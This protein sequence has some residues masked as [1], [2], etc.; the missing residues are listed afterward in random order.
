MKPFSLLTRE[1]IEQFEIDCANYF[2]GGLIDHSRA[3]S[4]VNDLLDEENTFELKVESF[5]YLAHMS[6]SSG[7]IGSTSPKWIDTLNK[8]QKGKAIR[9]P[10]YEEGADLEGWDQDIFL[11]VRTYF[12]V[13]L[14]INVKSSQQ[15]PPA[16]ITSKK[17]LEFLRNEILITANAYRII[18]FI[19]QKPLED[20]PQLF[21]EF[22][23]TITDFL[24]QM[25][26]L[27]QFCFPAGIKGHAIY[28]FFIRYEN[29]LVV[30]I[31]NFQKDAKKHSY[32]KRIE[33]RKEVQYSKPFC[34]AQIP[35]MQSRL[36]ED[37]SY[38]VKLISYLETISTAKLDANLDSIK[39][40][41]DSHGLLEV[42][43]NENDFG[44][45]RTQTV[46]NCVYINFN[47]STQL[48][49]LAFLNWHAPVYFYDREAEF[50]GRYIDVN[51]QNG[52]WQEYR[53]LISKI[54]AVEEGALRDFGPFQISM[55]TPTQRSSK[56]KLLKPF[57]GTSSFAEIRHQNFIYIDKSL[58]IKDII[59]TDSREA[60]VKVKVFTRPTRFGKSLNMSMIGYYLDYRKR[61]RSTHDN[62]FN[63][64]NNLNIQTVLG[65]SECHQN[66]YMVISLDF[67]QIASTTLDEF[68]IKLKRYFADLYDAYS[69]V[70]ESLIDGSRA[71]N[72]FYNIQ[73]YGEP[74][75]PDISDENLES[76]LKNL[77]A[78]CTIY[79]SLNNGKNHLREIKPIV[80]I[81][82]YDSPL[83]SARIHGFWEKAVDLLRTILLF[84]FK[85]NDEN[86]SKAVITGVTRLAGEKLFSPLGNNA[87]I[88]SLT[89]ER[90]SDCFGLTEEEL[91]VILVNSQY[92]D[93]ID[94]IMPQLERY[95]GHYYFGKRRLFN[96][97]SVFQALFKNKHTIGYHRY[98][99]PNEQ[100]KY[101]LCKH[102]LITMTDEIK[103]IIKEELLQLVNNQ[104]IPLPI[105]EAVSMHSDATLAPREW[106]YSLLYLCG[107]ITRIPVEDMLPNVHDYEMMVPNYECQQYFIDDILPALGVHL[108]NEKSLQF[109]KDRAL[110]IKDHGD[111]LIHRDFYLKNFGEL[112]KHY[113]VSLSIC[114]LLEWEDIPIHL[115]SDIVKACQATMPTAVEEPQQFMPTLRDKYWV[116]LDVDT[117]RFSFNS[118]SAHETLVH[119]VEE[120]NAALFNVPF[121][122]T[123]YK[124][125]TQQFT[126]ALFEADTYKPSKA[127][128]NHVFTMTCYLETHQQWPEGIVD[129]WIR[130]MHYYLYHGFNLDKA[131][132][133]YKLYD[134]WFQQT[135]NSL[136]SLDS[137][138]QRAIMYS[139]YGKLSCRLN[140]LDPNHTLQWFANADRLF[141]ES[142]QHPATAQEQWLNRVR[143]AKYYRQTF[144]YGDCYHCYERALSHCQSGTAEY[145]YTQIEMTFIHSL[146]MNEDNI[147]PLSLE[148]AHN[149]CEHWLGLL[150]KT[151]D[152]TAL[153]MKSYIRVAIVKS[154]L[155]NSDSQ[156]KNYFQK[157]L[158]MVNE[159]GGKE[160]LEYNKVLCSSYIVL[161]DDMLT[162]ESFSQTMVHIKTA[163]DSFYGAQDTHIV[164][165]RL[166][167]AQAIYYSQ[168]TI[169]LTKAKIFYDKAKE[170]LARIKATI[171]VQTSQKKPTQYVDRLILGF[172]INIG[173]IDRDMGNMQAAEKQTKTCLDNVCPTGP[174]VVVL[175]NN[176][177]ELA[178]SR[179]DFH[180]A[181]TRFDT[182]YQEMLK[183]YGREHV[184]TLMV[185]MNQLICRCYQGDIVGSDSSIQE[186]VTILRDAYSAGHSHQEL[187]NIA[188]QLSEAC[189]FIGNVYYARELIECA[190]EFY[191]NKKVQKVIVLSP[192][193]GLYQAIQ[194]FCMAIAGDKSAAMAKF[195]TIYQLFMMHQWQTYPSYYAILYYVCHARYAQLDMDGDSIQRNPFYA[196]SLSTLL[197]ELKA[198]LNH[199]R[200][201]FHTR[202]SQVCMLETKLHY[203]IGDFGT[204]HNSLREAEV[205]YQ[206]ISET[207]FKLMDVYYLETKM[208]SKC[209]LLA[210]RSV[211]ESRARYKK[212]QDFSYGERL[213][214]WAKRLK[215]GLLCRPMNIGEFKK[216]LIDISQGNN[217]EFHFVNDDVEKK[218][219]AL[220]I[221]KNLERGHVF[222]NVNGLGIAGVLDKITQ[223]IAL[224]L[225]R[226]DIEEVLAWV[227]EYQQQLEEYKA[228]TGD[229]FQIDTDKTVCLNLIYSVAF[230]PTHNGRFADLMIPIINEIPDE[231]RILGQLKAQHLHNLACW[232]NVQ[233]EEDT[234]KGNPEAAAWF[235]KAEAI[236]E[237]LKDKR[238]KS[239]VEY[240]HIL[241][242]KRNKQHY[243]RIIALLFH[244]GNFHPTL[245]TQGPTEYLNYNE[246]E[247]LLL[248]LSLRYVFEFHTKLRINIRLL[249][250]FLGCMTLCDIDE[251]N[252]PMPLESAIGDFKTIVDNTQAEQPRLFQY[253]G[254]YLLGCLYLR[255]GKQNEAKICFETS[256]KLYQQENPTASDT[257]L[258]NL[259]PCI[260]LDSL[261]RGLTLL[262]EIKQRKEKSSFLVS[263]DSPRRAAVN[264][265]TTNHSV[266]MAP[267]VFDW[268]SF[269]DK[270]LSSITQ[271][272]LYSGIDNVQILSHLEFD[273]L[274][275][276]LRTP[277]STSF[278]RNL[279]NL[280]EFQQLIQQAFETLKQAVP[281]FELPLLIMQ[282]DRLLIQ[283]PGTNMLKVFD[284]F[285]KDYLPP[286]VQTQSPLF[287]VMDYEL[288]TQSWDNDWDNDHKLKVLQSWVGDGLVIPNDVLLNLTNLIGLSPLIIKALTKY[289]QANPQLSFENFR[290]EEHER[291][292][293]DFPFKERDDDT[294]VSLSDRFFIPLI[295]RLRNELGLAPLLLGGTADKALLSRLLPLAVVNGFIHETW[296]STNEGSLTVAI[297]SHTQASTTILKS[298]NELMTKLWRIG[299]LKWEAKKQCY[300]LSP[301]LQRLLLNAVLQRY[302]IDLKP[303][304]EQVIYEFNAQFTPLFFNQ[305]FDY[306]LLCPIRLMYALSYQV[307]QLAT[308]TQVKPETWNEPLREAYALLLLRAA[309]GLH[310]EGE[311]LQ[312]KRL[313]DEAIALREKDSPG[314]RALTN[315]YYYLMLG[316]YYLVSGTLAEALQAFEKVL[317]KGVQT[318]TEKLLSQQQAIEA[319][320]SSRI[321]YVKFKQESFEAFNHLM[322]AIDL[323]QYLQK[324]KPSAYFSVEHAITLFYYGDCYYE[325]GHTDR[326]KKIQR[327]LKTAA[328][329]DNPYAIAIECYQQARACLVDFY[330]Q[331]EGYYQTKPDQHLYVAEVNFRLGRCQRVQGRFLE[332]EASLKAAMATFL[333]FYEK[334]NHNKIVLC[335]LELAKLDIDKRAP[336]DALLGRMTDLKPSMNSKNQSV[337]TEFHFVLGKIHQI[338]GDHQ[339]AKTC[340]VDAMRSL[341]SHAQNY[342][343]DSIGYSANTQLVQAISLSDGQP[344]QRIRHSLA[345]RILHQLGANAYKM[346]LY[347]DAIVLLHEAL[348]INLSRLDENWVFDDTLD[349]SQPEQPVY[350]PAFIVLNRCKHPRMLLTLYE[351]GNC[352]F[353]LGNYSLA[354]WLLKTVLESQEDIYGV[355][356]QALPDI[357]ATSNSLARVYLELGQWSNA[358]NWVS[359]PAHGVAETFEE[360]GRHHLAGQLYLARGDVQRAA[361]ELVQGIHLAQRLRQH[362]SS[363]QPHLVETRLLVTAGR[364]LLS[365]G[366]PI[367]SKQL[368]ER[369]LTLY[370]LHYSAQSTELARLY[371]ELAQFYLIHYDPIQ[372]TNW[373]TTSNA[374]YQA[375]FHLSLDDFDTRIH[376]PDL[377][378]WH[379]SRTW[380]TYIEAQHLLLTDNLVFAITKFE[381]ALLYYQAIHIAEGKASGNVLFALAGVYL[382]LYQLTKQVQYKDGFVRCFDTLLQLLESILQKKNPDAIDSVSWWPMVLY[383]YTQLGFQHSDDEAIQQ[384]CRKWVGV[385]S[386]LLLLLETKARLSNAFVEAFFTDINTCHSLTAAIKQPPLVVDGYLQLARLANV[387]NDD[388]LTKH[389]LNF[390]NKLI[391]QQTGHPRQ[392]YWCFYSDV[393]ATKNQGVDSSN[394]VNSIQKLRERFETTVAQAREVTVSERDY[395]RSELQWMEQSPQ[396]SLLRG[397]MNYLLPKPSLHMSIPAVGSVFPNITR[398]NIEMVLTTLRNQHAYVILGA[399]G[400]GKTELVRDV[401]Q[402]MAPLEVISLS[403]ASTDLFCLSLQEL[404]SKLKLGKIYSGLEQQ[405]L[406]ATTV[407]LLEEASSVVFLLDGFETVQRM[408]SLVS[409]FLT[410]RLLERHYVL[411]TCVADETQS[412]SLSKTSIILP[413]QGLR[414]EVF[415]LNQAN[416]SDAWTAELI[417]K[418]AIHFHGLA[419]LTSENLYQA[420]KLLKG[421]PLAVQ[422]FAVLCYHY[423]NT[424]KKPLSD[425]SEN[426]LLPRLRQ[427]DTI[428]AVQTLIDELLNTPKFLSSKA[429]ELFFRLVYF[430]P[431]QIHR[432][433]INVVYELPRQGKN[434]LLSQIDG[435]WP[436]ELESIIKLLVDHQFLLFDSSHQVYK[437]RPSIRLATLNY[438]Q[439]NMLF[440]YQREVY[441]YLVQQLGY[442]LQRGWM[443]SKGEESVLS[444]AL[445]L[446]NDVPFDFSQIQEKE[447]LQWLRV[448]LTLLI[449]EFYLYHQQYVPNV[450]DYLH[451]AQ[452]TLPDILLDDVSI[453]MLSQLTSD[454]RLLLARYLNLRAYAFLL[455][456]AYFRSDK[457]LTKNAK[458]V[459]SPDFLTSLGVDYADSQQVDN[460]YCREYWMTEFIY[461]LILFEYYHAFKEAEKKFK[462]LLRFLADRDKESAMIVAHEYARVLIEHGYFLKQEQTRHDKLNPVMVAANDQASAP[463]PM[464]PA[465]LW[466]CAREQ[467]QQAKEFH[468]A[469][470]RQ[471]NLVEQKHPRYVKI[472]LTEAKLVLLTE[473]QRFEST[474]ALLAKHPLLQMDSIE[475]YLLHSEFHYQSAQYDEAFNQANNALRSAE[476]YYTYSDSISSLMLKIYRQLGDVTMFMGRFSEAADYYKQSLSIAHRLL[477][478]RESSYYQWLVGIL[479]QSMLQALLF[480]HRFNE[481]AQAVRTIESIHALTSASTKTDNDFHH[482]AFF[483]LELRFYTALKE[484]N[485]DNDTSQAQLKRIRNDL[486]LNRKLADSCILPMERM[487]LA[488]FYGQLCYFLNNPLRAIRYFEQAVAY[489]IDR[490]DKDDNQAYQAICYCK[491]ALCHRKLHDNEQVKQ[492]FLKAL[493]SLQTHYIERGIIWHLFLADV[494]VCYAEFIDTSLIST[495]EEK[496][497]ISDILVTAK[498]IF[499]KQ[500]LISEDVFL[501]PIANDSLMQRYN[502]STPRLSLTKEDVITLVNQLFSMSKLK[503]LDVLLQAKNSQDIDLDLKLE[504]SPAFKELLADTFIPTRG[505]RFK[506]TR[507][508]INILS[509]NLAA[510]TDP[511]RKQGL[512]L[513]KLQKELE[514]TLKEK[515]I[516]YTCECSDDFDVLTITAD[517][518][519]IDAIIDLL[520]R[521]GMS[522]EKFKIEQY[523]TLFGKS[524]A[525]KEL[526]T[527]TSVSQENQSQINCPIQ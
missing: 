30:R 466:K 387:L 467:L 338:L 447:A 40:I 75:Q 139:L 491:L 273:G 298:D 394:F 58:L 86:Y 194:A 511:Q 342:T 147:L 293:Y 430:D 355:G 460:S 48:R 350:Q 228:K 323:H 393:L 42:P 198:Y 256:V 37:N 247:A 517:K 431:H 344:Y 238:P 7:V 495:L 265:Q 509:I 337:M 189:L 428:R 364:C 122:H 188:Y 260:K 476:H 497:L 45:E 314:A 109:F 13:E 317:S 300:W 151:R 305:T 281:A 370:Q 179:G 324:N 376:L 484:V 304:I 310:V 240:A 276:E 395:L 420:I 284:K 346:G 182:I 54:K 453:D 248:C 368:F 377:R 12:L 372:L 257:R 474:I 67:L 185:R 119:C 92:A 480:T 413:Y 429:R 167:L 34:L 319:I 493:S 279:D 208:R 287:D 464:A 422:M 292:L 512:H 417:T 251:T 280:L 171:E 183:Y 146:L 269:Q 77:L 10:V 8:D 89:N 433:L 25:P 408:R 36:E 137:R 163:F 296:F 352:H 149:D 130:L 478:A 19:L 85:G 99:L 218:Q 96:P 421:N 498:T 100:G 235:R 470:C 351:L 4:L 5:K 371:C 465:I 135:Q 332:S 116:Y 449:A 138:H 17:F 72:Y 125:L 389:Y 105:T 231:N 14:F 148:K 57:L 488:Y 157:A 118:K 398:Q 503:D 379:Q 31:D 229:T 490:T 234:L 61:P 123:V 259:P 418:L 396:F 74:N 506:L 345:A 385:L 308:H 499:D 289:S 425:Y 126:F 132:Q 127:I 359:N 444:H 62:L 315:G 88:Y 333:A 500:Q 294:E 20:H 46:G 272:F 223:L 207:H 101:D 328:A 178:M 254:H 401:A 186:H 432:K 435:A 356:R 508:R 267:D 107:F 220:L 128:A 35:L 390:A 15:L 213:Y 3:K 225:L 274:Y 496:S 170:L 340:Y 475:R 16:D 131:K 483:L 258:N 271:G 505:Y 84:A 367:E 78:F 383:P 18:H 513:D 83:V 50:A 41:Y 102:I 440:E 112:N 472:I 347:N 24:Y 397:P 301:L 348:Q 311:T 477:N 80:L 2:S 222:N 416:H 365:I 378:K 150:E 110:L 242:Q 241:Y 71:K 468:E 117:Q 454:Q 357:R 166:Y 246:T 526:T 120:M 471:H 53:T 76:V 330:S 313:L 216:A 97:W 307:L 95:Y 459:I 354:A 412:S 236:F 521:Q 349:A 403:I 103:D 94:E 29:K 199:Q 326:A 312:S 243:E 253:V 108:T 302:N 282:Y 507:N 384:D 104:F 230:M 363:Q 184:Q 391:D 450:N 414:W 134:A 209:P 295:Q 152:K 187:A 11:S 196:K 113:S 290:L 343:V 56:K 69:C 527:T 239:R 140:Q 63:Y 1:K 297:P 66:Q 244:D 190:L 482:I 473:P 320:A 156:I 87:V 176:L 386:R 180:T 181:Q 437:I 510:S 339:K 64:P 362:M 192:W 98:W 399:E 153:L 309:Y 283:H 252:R 129:T 327:P 143:W 316:K 206:H 214:Q 481:F 6:N 47:V 22:L 291:A 217:G 203:L 227:D 523:A 226:G 237:E 145:Y 446:I 124:V 144:Q 322:Q 434:S 177:A 65:F 469:F 494:L 141:T 407:S 262:D 285:L 195:D 516:I 455:Q 211:D 518:R 426:Q 270:V 443:F 452:S 406:I 23:T 424:L 33:K 436:E 93:R 70:F 462:T 411:M 522:L 106:F 154:C 439:T 232:Y 81:D 111:R 28:L 360:A 27:S 441:Q 261:Q 164:Y 39:R 504:L 410:P 44:F 264:N 51:K 169:D 52:L 114:A 502:N 60:E 90:Y 369:A 38:Q 405:E 133:V 341:L 160:H 159:S 21:R 165:L 299:L 409:R 59:E 415:D 172:D 445:S 458:K 303:T 329:L 461:A 381:E 335:Q 334:E 212:A 82:E 519:E 205:A 49:A 457:I 221:N 233:S 524:G 515:N 438:L 245:A 263:F 318:V 174:D 451:K 463:H 419:Q 91:R 26:V 489:L 487:Q 400:S 250:Y 55:K 200:P 224:Y 155:R 382:R 361:N 278:Y 479:E 249:A 485:V 161:G 374:I 373:L 456:S 388:S 255:T 215:N 73:H 197:S 375:I 162:Q 486:D 288:T 175:K 448:E 136:L 9:V 142:Q 210:G 268:R 121:I 173:E 427:R 79:N 275:I 325:L 380:H 68:K 277:G 392:L 286:N 158:N 266:T 43:L 353:R 520:V 358:A 514:N 442:E 201:Y 115:V 202:Y 193:Y 191:E 402:Q 336:S 321:G 501:E 404:L 219:L 366:Y 32:E 168:K 492:H 525:F 423:V 204:A 331:H 306:A